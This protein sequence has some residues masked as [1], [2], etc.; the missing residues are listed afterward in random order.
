MIVIMPSTVKNLIL[1]K[2]ST[3]AMDN[4]VRDF[5]TQIG[6]AKYDIDK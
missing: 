3:T 6:W 5:L 4:S 1:K 2:L